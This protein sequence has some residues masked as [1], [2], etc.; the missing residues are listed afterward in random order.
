MQLSV[1]NM[2]P[3]NNHFGKK[4]TCTSM[5]IAAQFTIAKTWKKHKCHQQMNGLRRRSTCIQ[6]NTTQP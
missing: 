1:I 2:K 6:R 4:D 3:L 5:F